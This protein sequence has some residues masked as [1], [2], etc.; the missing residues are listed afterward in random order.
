MGMPSRINKLERAPKG[1]AKARGI[2]PHYLKATASLWTIEREGRDDGV[3]SN[4]QGP[5]KSRDVRRTVM[6]LGEE[7]EG[8]PI[9]P[10]V[11]RL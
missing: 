9:M 7:M 1:F 10:D 5:P 8:G 3:P 4:F 6:F 2:I 11:I